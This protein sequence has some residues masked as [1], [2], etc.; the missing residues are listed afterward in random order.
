M[1]KFDGDERP[2]LKMSQPFEARH[3]EQTGG[4]TAFSGGVAVRH[5]TAAYRIQWNLSTEP[6]QV[7]SSLHLLF[8]SS[9]QGWARSSTGHELILPEA[10]TGSDQYPRLCSW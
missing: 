5:V 6:P 10:S 2:I 9:A 1:D 7:L 3:Q 8:H 4:A